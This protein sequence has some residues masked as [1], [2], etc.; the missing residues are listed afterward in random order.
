M[1]FVNINLDEKEEI[2]LR[3]YSMKAGKSLS[4]LFKSAILCQI[5]D[6]LA[7]ETGIKALE[8]FEKNSVS[9]SIDDLISELE[10]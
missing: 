5:E 4:D 3:T 9:Y 8:D 10:E 1:A 7:Y 6:E 2:L